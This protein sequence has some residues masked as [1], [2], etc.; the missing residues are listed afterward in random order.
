MLHK[1]VL[2]LAFVRYCHFHFGPFVVY[3]TYVLV[4]MPLSFVFLAI[5]IF[6]WDVYVVILPLLLL[7]GTTAYFFRQW[8]RNYL[9]AF[10]EFP[11]EHVTIVAQTLT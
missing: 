11:F 3:L 5:I 2:R 7:R 1:L 4:F 8:R 9:Y 10:V 6:W